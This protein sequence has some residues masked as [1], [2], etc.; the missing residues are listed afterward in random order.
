MRLIWVTLT[1]YRLLELV[2]AAV[3]SS[4]WQGS[5]GV[6]INGSQN[7]DFVCLVRGLL[8]VYNRNPTNH[9][10]RNYLKQYLA[11]QAS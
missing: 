11:V 2:A 6:T 4:E 7:A 9:D 10:L 5:D 8:A 3:S 1:F